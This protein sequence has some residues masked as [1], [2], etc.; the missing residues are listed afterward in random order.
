MACTYSVL[1]SISFVTPLAGGGVLA[2]GITATEVKKVIEDQGGITG[3]IK[4]LQKM[5]KQITQTLEKQDQEIT[6]IIQKLE[7]ASAALEELKIMLGKDILTALDFLKNESEDSVGEVVEWFKAC[8]R[9]YNN[10]KEDFPV[11]ILAYSMVHPSS[12][13]RAGFELSEVQQTYLA[14]FQHN[15]EQAKHFGTIERIAAELYEDETKKLNLFFNMAIRFMETHCQDDQKEFNDAEYTEWNLIA[16]LTASSATPNLTKFDLDLVRKLGVED[17]ILN[18]TIAAKKYQIG[19][20]VAQH[21]DMMVKKDA[22]EILQGNKTDIMTLLARSA[23]IYSQVF[24]EAK[25]KEYTAILVYTI[26]DPSGSLDHDAYEGSLQAMTNTAHNHEN[27]NI[28]DIASLLYQNNH[29]KQDVLIRKVAKHL[30]QQSYC[31]R[32]DSGYDIDGFAENP[33]AKECADILRQT[34]ADFAEEIASALTPP[35]TVESSPRE[36]SHAMVSPEAVSQFAYQGNLIDGKDYAFRAPAPI[37]SI[38]VGE[39]YDLEAK[40]Q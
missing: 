24:D 25:A 10:I 29:D 20:Y 22:V 12:I 26:I 2:G 15:E 13:C 39:A 3:V 4:K 32:D 19:Q 33:I 31:L 36:D 27:I 37:S 28:R 23:K 1:Q 7:E 30:M 40:G 34:P 17:A 35:L 9:E 5:Q 21:L 6:E 16:S 11:A 14:G 38:V 8:A 18:P